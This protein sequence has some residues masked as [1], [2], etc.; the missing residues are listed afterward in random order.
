MANTLAFELRLADKLSAPARA[1]ANALKAVERQLKAVNSAQAIVP[2]RPI[3]VGS[4]AS[5]K[6]IKAEQLAAEKAAAK[7]R[8]ATERAAAREL[9]AIRR[10]QAAEAKALARAAAAEQK[11]AQRAAL[12]QTKATAKAEAQAVKDA[13]KAK[14]AAEQDASKAAKKAAAEQTARGEAFAAEAAG[15]ASAAGAAATA[16][17]ALAAAFGAA[18]YAGAA[19]AIQAAEAKGDTLDMLEAFMGSAEAANDTY[20]RIQDITRD[21]ALSQSKAQELAQTLT[22]AGVTNQAMLLDAIKSI[23]QVDSV[24][25]GA[26]DK[27][28][29]IIETANTA[30]KFQINAKKLVGTGI[31]MQALF[32]QLAKDTGKGVKQV[33]AELKAGKIS[34]EVGVAALTKTIDT[35]FGGLAA[36]QVLDFGAQMQRF[37]DNIGRLFEDVDTGPF[38]SALKTVLDLFDQSTE[39]G[40]FLKET[41]TAAFNGLFN[42][43]AAIA[44]YVTTFFKGLI[45]IGLRVYIALKPLLK[46]FGLIGSAAKENKSSA[47]ALANTMGVL[48]DAITWVVEQFV[49]LLSHKSVLVVLGITAAAVV[50][51]FVLMQA[52]LVAVVV[53]ITAFVA[54]AAMAID[55]LLNLGQSAWNAGSA[56][57]GGLIDGIKAAGAKLIAAVKNL[58]GD[59]LKT[60]KNIFKIASPSKVMMSM[61]ENLSLGLAEGIAA[62][63]PAVN[64]NM[65][66]VVS[67]PSLPP[68]AAGAGGG[69]ASSS[70]AF[71]EGS[72]VVHIHGVE[73][74]EELEEKLPEI[75]GNVMEQ[76]LLARGQSIQ[77]AA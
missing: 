10:Q 47:E 22:A 16:V 38:L 72:I 71:G 41:L 63:A 64:D 24:I 6:A 18:V 53:G 59:A 31:Q 74:A 19:L 35:K 25:K 7:Q 30:G 1:G 77:P 62:E 15:M 26:G 54:A 52:I 2:Q 58:A 51:P 28:Q 21:V 76:A 36:G 48:A 14:K 5:D 45:I 66:A 3:A 8:V 65:A 49:K 11:A 68:Q 70:V 34:A 27:V 50:L 43:I 57:V 46:Q 33:E 32:E 4:A 20:D 12:A 69:T 61:G 9:T 40:K 29:A 44:P 73:N 56:L 39:S 37:K 13:A 17:L 75:M 67:P 60:F 23:G 55:W 42:A